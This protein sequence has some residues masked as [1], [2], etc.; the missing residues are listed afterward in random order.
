M[1]TIKSECEHGIL[2]GTRCFECDPPDTIYEL[3]HHNW[4]SLTAE[5]LQVLNKIL[6][7]IPKIK[8][9]H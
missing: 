1:I 9:L 7:V 5:E 4:F 6:L 2:F 3:F 8:L